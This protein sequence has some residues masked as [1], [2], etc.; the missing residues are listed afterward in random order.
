MK[1]LTF[2]VPLLSKPVGLKENVKKLLGRLPWEEDDNIKRNLY[3]DKLRQAFKD[4][5]F[6]LAAYEAA[7]AGGERSVFARD[8]RTYDLLRKA[9]T[10][11][12]GHL[13]RIGRQ[14]MAIELLRRLVAL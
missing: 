6:D 2:T 4:S 5:L 9:Y 14:I 10:S 12:G 13:N 8:G 11:D 3:N 1:I 7:G